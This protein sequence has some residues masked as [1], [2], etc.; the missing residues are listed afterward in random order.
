MQ[1]PV[2]GGKASDALTDMLQ[3]AYQISE[4]LDADLCDKK[5]QSLT[6]SAA[7]DLRALAKHYDS[8]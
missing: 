8:E 1:L 4:L 2:Y 7:E 3:C 6:E 5:R